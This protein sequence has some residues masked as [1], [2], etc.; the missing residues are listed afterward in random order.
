MIGRLFALDKFRFYRLV[1]NLHRVYGPCVIS[2]AVKSSHLPQRMAM[3][4]SFFAEYNFSIEYNPGR[5]NVDADAVL[6]R[7]DFEPT[8]IPNIK[9]AT[10]Y[11]ITSRFLSSTLL[12]DALKAYAQVTKVL[13]LMCQLVNLFQKNLK[14]LPEMYR[15]SADRYTTLHGL[16]YYTA[17]TGDTPLI[18]VP[19][20][21]DMRMRTMQR[22]RG[23]PIC[24]HRGR[25]RIFIRSDVVATGCIRISSCASRLVRANTVN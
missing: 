18:V 13:R 2:T 6:R 8:S 14:G 11:G 1:G 10:I 3:W 12:D 24:G 7:P 23:S 15:F 17:I 19:V 5:L 22:C 21:N 25:D 4:L 20:Q 16:L 9:T